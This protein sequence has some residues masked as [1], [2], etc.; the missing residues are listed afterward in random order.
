MSVFATT[1]LYVVFLAGCAAIVYGLLLWNE[2]AAWVVG[3]IIAV[4]LCV[5][6]AR[7]NPPAGKAG[8]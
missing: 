3:G 4:V 1:L 7:F 8:P 5:L 2:S 6:T